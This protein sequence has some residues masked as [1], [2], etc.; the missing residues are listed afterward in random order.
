MFIS[1]IPA[2]IHSFITF[3]LNISHEQDTMLTGS[4][5]GYKDALYILLALKSLQS[6]CFAQLIP[7]KCKFILN[8]IFPLLMYMNALG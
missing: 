1:Y 8:V 4:D 2:Y 7:C 3:Y 5:R 6:S